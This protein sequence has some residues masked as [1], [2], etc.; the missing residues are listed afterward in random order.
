MVSAFGADTQ[1]LK[2]CPK[3]NQFIIQNIMPKQQQNNINH[4][5]NQNLVQKKGKNLRFRVKMR[6]E[7]GEAC[8][9]RGWQWADREKEAKLEERKYCANS[10]GGFCCS[11]PVTWKCQVHLKGSKFSDWKF[12]W[13]DSPLEPSMS[14]REHQPSNC[15]CLAHVWGYLNNGEGGQAGLE[16]TDLI[17]FQQR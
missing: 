13:E 1:L 11:F 12:S 2:S 6:E 3:G 16:Q 4:T 5:Q 7:P 17:V 14:S 8:E 15:S 10:H 9:Q